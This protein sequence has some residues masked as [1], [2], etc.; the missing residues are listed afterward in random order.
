M[1]FIYGLAKPY[2]SALEATNEHATYHIAK[3]RSAEVTTTKHYLTAR[4]KISTNQV[5]ACYFVE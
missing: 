5:R 4:N 3:V 2:G 1:L